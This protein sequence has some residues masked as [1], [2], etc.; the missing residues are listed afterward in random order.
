MLATRR[1]H[2]QVPRLVSV[3]VLAAVCALCLMASQASARSTFKPPPV[4]RGATYLALGDSVTF[5]YME[6][7][8]VPAPNYYDPS[9]FVGYPQIVGRLLRL[10]AVNAACP[11][12]TSSSFINTSAQSN[13]CENSYGGGSAYRT[14][15]PLH[16]HYSG[17]QLAFAVSYLKRNRKVRLVSLMI[18]AND[19]FLCEKTTSDGCLSASEQQTVFT[20]VARNTKTIVSTIRKKAGYRGQ[21][22]IVNYYSLNYASSLLNTAS[23]GVN[24][25]MDTAAK[26]F[27]VQIADGYG[28]F[29]AATSIF[30]GSTCS[31]GLLTKL[32]TG[33]CGVHPTRA[34]QGLLAQAVVYALRF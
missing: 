22:V 26:P 9:S 27:K 4:V 28:Q 31:A 18:G 17:S 14:L 10:K 34:G 12:E 20:T 6:P 23:L 5:G 16:V 11:G 2:T 25:A 29:Q 15:Y 32:S 3:V 13:G 8:V 33:S 21:I 19:L 30:G 24:N 1:L 7:N